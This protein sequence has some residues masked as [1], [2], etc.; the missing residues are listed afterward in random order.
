MKHLHFR[1]QLTEV[2]SNHPSNK[3]DTNRSLALV[4]LPRSRTQLQTALLLFLL[5]TLV[6]SSDKSSHGRHKVHTLLGQRGR[7]M[8]HE[9]FL[10]QIEGWPWL[11]Y[12]VVVH[13]IHPL[14]YTLLLT[15]AAAS[16][17]LAL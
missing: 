4:V 14:H 5:H 17:N 13:N 3:S 10:Q 7:N 9:H 8:D 15:A 16:G 11:H 12:H 1:T 6:D 2:E